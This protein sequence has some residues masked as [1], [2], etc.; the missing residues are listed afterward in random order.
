MGMK[1]RKHLVNG[2]WMTVAQVA[3]ALGEC[4]STLYSHISAHRQPDGQP[5][6]LQAV[7]DHYTAVREGRRPRQ[8]PPTPPR[9]PV[10]GQAMTVKEAA[11]ALGENPGTV[12]CWQTRHRQPNGDRGTLQAAWDHFT[13]VREGRAPRRQPGGPAKH[14]VH[15][16]WMTL[17]EAARRLG[18]SKATIVNWRSAHRR[19]DG[20]TG[21]LVDC[22]DH[23]AALN[24]GKIKPGKREGKRYYVKGRHITVAEA[25]GMLGITEKAL[26]VYLSKHKCSLNSAVRYY[27][28]RAK[29]QAVR[30]I[31]EIIGDRE[32]GTGNRDSGR[33]VNPV[34]ATQANPVGDADGNIRRSIWQS[35]GSGLRLSRAR[36]SCANSLPR[37]WWPMA[38][39]SSARRGM[40]SPRRCTM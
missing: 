29:D 5:C 14:L 19:P 8:L 7:W 4:P 18:R 13:A 33:R 21:L 2:Q 10:H 15:G 39:S 3:E 12:A 22:W 20:G 23:Y 32:Q 26:R 37:G 40:G 17:E 16:E 35:T 6:T 30:E 36:K 31:M 38:L 34:A 27:E 25:A 11:E 1:A 24:A 28:N 9:Y